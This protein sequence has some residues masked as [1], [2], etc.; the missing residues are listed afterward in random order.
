MAL[1]LHRIAIGNFLL[2]VSVALDLG[3]PSA[4]SLRSGAGW[5]ISRLDPCAWIAS[6]GCR[7]AFPQLIPVLFYQL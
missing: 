4:A 7:R 5:P 1:N 3:C 6:I 2:R